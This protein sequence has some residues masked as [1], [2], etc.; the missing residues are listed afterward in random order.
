MLKKCFFFK[1]CIFFD[2]KHYN[3][4]NGNTGM[5]FILIK[6]AYP[7]SALKIIQDYAS[8]DKFSCEMTKLSIKEFKK[9]LFSKKL[10][11][12]QTSRIYVIR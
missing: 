12:L 2:K 4:P 6:T 5:L 8:L 11:F 1:K 9:F 3:A 7:G 10:F